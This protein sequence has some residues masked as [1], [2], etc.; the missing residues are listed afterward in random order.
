MG[1]GNGQAAVTVAEVAAIDR[2]GRHAVGG[3]VVL[4]LREVRPGEFARSW[5]FRYRAG[6]RQ[7]EMGLGPARIGAPSGVTLAEARAAAEAARKL[8]RAGVDPLEHRQ[9]QRARQA[10]ELAR[11]VTFDTFAAR[12]I[13]RQAPGW[14]NPKHHQQWVNTLATYAS[15]LI[16]TMPIGAIATPDVLRVLTPIWTAKPETPPVSSVY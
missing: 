10:A 6:D 11:A 14:R 7:R 1:Q 8:L 13:E 5:L 16:G 12:F 9:A 2:P 3:Q 4:Q 15:P